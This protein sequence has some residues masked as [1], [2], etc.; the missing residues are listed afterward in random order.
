MLLGGRCDV[1]NSRRTVIVLEVMGVDGGVFQWVTRVDVLCIVAVVSH[2]HTIVR[3]L[4]TT[5]DRTTREGVVDAHGQ[6][7]VFR[8]W[9]S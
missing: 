1:R 3:R 9:S 5:Y 8:I 6:A 2:K 4:S 7:D